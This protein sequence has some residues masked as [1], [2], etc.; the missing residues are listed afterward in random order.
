MLYEGFS[1]SNSEQNE[2]IENQLQI[3]DNIG[4]F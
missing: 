1:V 3:Q 4:W 2:M